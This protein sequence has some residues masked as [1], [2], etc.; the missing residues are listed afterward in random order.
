MEWKIGCLIASFCRDYLLRKEL[1]NLDR[2]K[3]LRRTT[4]PLKVSNERD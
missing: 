1:C 3:K 4:W 2:Y